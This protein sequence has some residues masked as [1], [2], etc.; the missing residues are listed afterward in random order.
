M[1]DPCFPPSLIVLSPAF[2]LP[3]ESGLGASR[4]PKVAL[5]RQVLLMFICCNYS[6]LMGEAQ[7]MPKYLPCPLGEAM[8]GMT[9]LWLCGSAALLPRLLHR[10]AWPWSHQVG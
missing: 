6:A 2:L 3:V 5:A 10:L 9:V 7:A 1:S 4:G 8:Q